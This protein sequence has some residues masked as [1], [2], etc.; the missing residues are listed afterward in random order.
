MQLSSTLCIMFTTYMY[1]LLHCSAAP[2]SASFACIDKN[3][4]VSDISLAC[5]EGT[6]LRDVVFGQY[7]FP[8]G[9]CAT[10]LI[11]KSC[12]TGQNK[13]D[14]HVAW[15][16]S[17]ICQGSQ[18]CDLASSFQKEDTPDN[19][20]GDP[21]S[22]KPRK[23]IAVQVSCGQPYPTPVLPPSPWSTS[24]KF[25]SAN[26]NVTATILQNLYSIVENDQFP[27]QA[28]EATLVDLGLDVSP[29]PAAQTL[30]F[31]YAPLV[32][33]QNYY[34]VK[35]FGLATAWFGLFARLSN[36]GYVSISFRG[37]LTQTDWAYG[38]DMAHAPLPDEM[39]SPCNADPN[40][41]VHRGWLSL[42]TG[43][44]KKLISAV[45]AETAV[46]KQ[47]ILSG[48]SLGSAFATLAAFDLM[49]L[50][51][52]IHSVY[53]FASPRVGNP[54][55]VQAYHQLM[56]K[57]VGVDPTDLS[58][59]PHYRIANTV[60]II[61]NTPIAGMPNFAKY[62]H[63]GSSQY[64]YEYVPFN[65]MTVANMTG[66]NFEKWAHSLQTYI[67]GANMFLPGMM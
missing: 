52:D 40:I 39:S 20:F 53:A 38:A 42:Y 61:T 50:G 44:R 10:G 22:F 45:F 54:A 3:E 58:A 18:Q 41:R 48:H 2:I 43:M 14:K 27:W 21:C 63:V 60:D 1:L 47:F 55:F 57:Y 8:K 34:H 49:C 51:H 15:V 64:T 4:T 13:T 11:S 25:N 29:G 33:Y 7:G 66:P 30:P 17:S 56:A 5:P 35:G 9:S 19:V 28:F 31:R 67:D 59:L 62:M 37:T 24:R 6:V 26:L 36:P 23:F 12:G 46:A 32:T 65:N 16:V